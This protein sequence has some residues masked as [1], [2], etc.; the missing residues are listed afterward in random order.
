VDIDGR[1][2]ITAVRTIKNE[3]RDAE[4][5]VNASSSN[6]IYVHFSEQVKE[7]VVVRLISTTGQIVSQKT[8]DE[9]VGQVVVAAQNTIKG[10]Y[11]ITATDGQ[12]LK[13]SKQIL[14]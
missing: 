14:L 4:I 3:N 1:F 12:N 6:S 2:T 10:I 5:K 9:S 8:F 11:I 7:N 13:F